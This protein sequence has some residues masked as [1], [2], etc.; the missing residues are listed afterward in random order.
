[1][2]SLGRHGID[3]PGMIDGP[4]IDMGQIHQLHRRMAQVADPHL[5]GKPAAVAMQLDH[6]LGEIVRG[7]GDPV[8]IAAGKGHEGAASVLPGDEPGL[9][10]AGIGQLAMDWMGIL[11]PRIAHGGGAA[12]EEEGAI[13]PEEIHIGQRLVEHQRYK[14]KVSLSTKQSRRSQAA[15]QSPLHSRRLAFQCIACHLYSS[16]PT[17]LASV[18]GPRPGATRPLSSWS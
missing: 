15:R 6:R 7:E 3:Q 5:D 18:C 9:L 1:M 14:S 11:H 17:A 2:S 13:A 8:P 12:M 4:E 16:R 10:V